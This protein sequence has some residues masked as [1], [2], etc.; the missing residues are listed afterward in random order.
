MEWKLYKASEHKQKSFETC[1]R[2][3]KILGIKESIKIDQ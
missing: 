2:Q 3:G 1:F